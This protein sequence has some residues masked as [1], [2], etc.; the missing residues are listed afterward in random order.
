M[1]FEHQLIQDTAVTPR[2][3]R[4]EVE[5]RDDRGDFGRRD[6]NIDDNITVDR[7]IKRGSINAASFGRDSGLFS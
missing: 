3:D 5:P 4:R 1:L 2:D 7:R 6:D